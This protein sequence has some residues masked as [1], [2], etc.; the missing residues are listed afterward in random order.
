VT[1]TPALL[2]L[3]GEP[4]VELG[5]VHEHGD[6]RSLPV[7]LVEDG[8]EHAPQPPQVPQDLEQPHHG[9]VPDVGDEPPARFLEPVPAEPEHIQRAHS[10]VEVADQVAGVEVSRRLAA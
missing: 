9:E 4:Q 6:G 2:Q 5:V 8:T 1:G 7:H 10:A 3:A